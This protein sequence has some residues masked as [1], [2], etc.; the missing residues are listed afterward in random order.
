LANQVVNRQS[1]IENYVLSFAT[2]FWL[3][4]RLGLEPLSWLGRLV[5]GIFHFLTIL[6]PALVLTVFAR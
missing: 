3:L 2:E 6:V 5:A 4:R 1:S